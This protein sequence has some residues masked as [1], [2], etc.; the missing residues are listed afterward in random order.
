MYTIGEFS[1]INR[2]TTKTL[3]HYERIGLFKPAQVDEWSGYRYYTRE[4]LQELARILELRELG[5][6]L[7]EI[8]KI[9]RE[10]ARLARSLHNRIE[11]L[12]NEREVLAMKIEHAQNYLDRLTTNTQSHAQAV[13]KPLPEV[14]VASMRTQI[15]SYDSYFEIVPKMGEYMHSVGAVCRDPA[16]CFTIYHDMEY[17]ER[18]IDA[19]ICE[20]VI[21]PCQESERVK[22]KTIEAVPTAACL[23]HKGPYTT[24]HTSYNAVF[25]WIAE[26][27][28]RPSGPPRE[29]YI[30]GIWNRN[31]PEDWLT[32]IQVPVIRE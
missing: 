18:D 9:V 7:S 5:F 16:Y 23:L 15:P 14:I 27:G 12:Q 21:A 3:R 25:M 4:Q 32:E 19:E 1:R 24:L 29:S 22:F 11:E 20:A 10:G 31:N 26:Q 28:L 17:R 30:D 13:L 2:V 8:K 6:S